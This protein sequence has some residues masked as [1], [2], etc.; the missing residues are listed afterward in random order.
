VPSEIETQTE[1]EKN[2]SLIAS[3]E[4]RIRHLEER[5]TESNTIESTQL[6]RAEKLQTKL[7]QW[8]ET[9]EKQVK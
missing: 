5:L 3:I 2:D 6:V 8:V 1:A 9:I 4:G 7:N